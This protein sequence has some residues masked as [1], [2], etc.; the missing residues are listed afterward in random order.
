MQEI[1][2]KPCPFCGGQPDL[3]KNIFSD[4]ETWKVVCHKC[5]IGTYAFFTLKH[6]AKRWNRR[7]KQ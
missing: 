3:V 4:R 5:E 1:E 6:A 2:L 7:V